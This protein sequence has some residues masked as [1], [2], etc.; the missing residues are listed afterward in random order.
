MQ[1][2]IP[3]LGCSVLLI[4]PIVAAHHNFAAHYRGDELIEHVG[5]IT[6]FRFVNPHA[7][8]YLEV[9]NEN[10]EVEQWMAEGDASVALRRSGWTADQLK[11]GDRIHIVGNP[12]HNGTNTMS[13]DA[14]TFV[15]GTE[16]G[17][18][19]G[20]LDERVTILSRKLAEFRTQ[21]GRES[22]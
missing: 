12:S 4:T 16:I 14:I 7:R 10:G 19:D 6:E 20:R 11:P 18:G 1:W 21:R 17:G 13:W 22:R 5:V 8:I 2:K 15:D 3:I 9:S